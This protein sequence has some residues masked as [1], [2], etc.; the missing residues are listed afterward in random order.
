MSSEWLV[1]TTEHG[2]LLHDVKCGIPSSGDFSFS[3]VGLLVAMAATAA[4]EDYEPSL[5]RSDDCVVA[6]M[7]F[8]N[9]LM[10]LVSSQSNIDESMLKHRLRCI[11]NGMLTVCPRNSLHELTATGLKKVIRQSKHFINTFLS[12]V[13]DVQPLVQLCVPE[14]VLCNNVSVAHHDLNL[15][16]CLNGVAEQ[17]SVSLVALFAG[18]R[19][20]AGSNAWLKLDGRDAMSIG[21]TLASLTS[22]SK[23]SDYPLHLPFSVMQGQQQADPESQWR[24]TKVRL[25]GA[26]DIVMICGEQPTLKDIT[27]LLPRVFDQNTIKDIRNANMAI[28]THVSGGIRCDPGLHAFLFQ[29]PSSYL[30][31]CMEPP[32][33]PN[34]ASSRARRGREVPPLDP[35]ARQYRLLKL[36]GFY[37]MFSPQLYHDEQ[38]KYTSYSQLDIRWG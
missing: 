3:Q 38:R 34:V 21:V 1:L 23:A 31:T 36:M 5:L 37:H 30:L 12:D 24:L 16:D 9:L 28:P 7:K 27:R 13:A 17:F 6:L 10:F 29:T 8:Q 2:S 11:Y 22:G 4:H 20:L 35:V 33:Q 18:H 14:I 26:I 19:L 32:I 25:V 15:V